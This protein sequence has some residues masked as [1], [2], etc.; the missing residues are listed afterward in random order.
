MKLIVL[1]ISMLCCV[2]SSLAQNTSQPIQFRPTTFQQADLIS[3]YTPVVPFE[4]AARFTDKI[5][6]S[7][8]LEDEKLF[9]QL[10]D[11]NYKTELAIGKIGTNEIRSSEK[12]IRRLQLASI[13]Q[14][15]NPDQFEKF[16]EEFGREFGQK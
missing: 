4:K 3:S 5:F 1:S 12:E 16:L 8:N 7:L 9:D 11:V 14:I 6:E 10:L 15:L 2:F 13:K